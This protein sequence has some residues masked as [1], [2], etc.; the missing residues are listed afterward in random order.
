MYQWYKNTSASNTGGTPI[1]GETGLTF[2]PPTNVDGTFYYYMVATYAAEGTS[3]TTSVV[4]ITIIPGNT[5]IIIN[6]EVDFDD[7]IDSYD[8]GT[9]DLEIILT[10]YEDYDSVYYILNGSTPVEVIDGEI[11]IANSGLKASNNLLIV[12]KLGEL[13]Y[14]RQITVIKD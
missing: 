13:A 8:I 11:N 6:P 10:N 12:V 7:V 9:D 14:S 5:E 4:T 3:A 1:E 2:T